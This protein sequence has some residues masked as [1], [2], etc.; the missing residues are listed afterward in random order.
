MASQ[1]DKLVQRETTVGHSQ[2]TAS[3]EYGPNSNGYRHQQIPGTGNR[4]ISVHYN[5]GP[6]LRQTHPS[7]SSPGSSTVE[8]HLFQDSLM[9]KCE[10]KV[11]WNRERISKKFFLKVN[12]MLPHFTISAEMI[13]NLWSLGAGIEP[14]SNIVGHI[15]GY[16]TDSFTQFDICECYWNRKRSRMSPLGD[17]MI[18]VVPQQITSV[19]RSAVSL[20]RLQLTEQEVREL[21]DSTNGQDIVL[22]QEKLNASLTPRDNFNRQD[23][24]VP[25]NFYNCHIVFSSDA[26]N[27]HL[28]LKAHLIFPNMTFEMGPVNPLKVVETPLTRSL[29]AKTAKGSKKETQSFRTGF[30]TLDQSKRVLPLECEDEMVSQFALVGIWVSGV[31]LSNSGTNKYSCLFNAKVWAACMR[32]ILWP[33]IKHRV[34]PSPN[35]NT[36]LLVCFRNEKTPLFVEVSTVVNND[37]NARWM[38]AQREFRIPRF[39]SKFNRLDL[40]FDFLNED[41]DEET[42]LKMSTIQELYH[43]AVRGGHGP[44]AFSDN[45]SAENV[46]NM[47]GSVDE[48]N[49]FNNDGSTLDDAS[50]DCPR[51]GQQR[52]MHFKRS[53]MNT[54]C[55]SMNEEDY[56]SNVPSRDNTAKKPTRRL[57]RN[58][59][60]Q[61]TP[62]VSRQ[63]GNDGNRITD[64]AGRKALD[65]E[66]HM[67]EIN[68][69]V[70]QR[71][72]DFQTRGNFGTRR[73]DF[74]NSSE[75]LMGLPLDGSTKQRKLPEPYPHPH[76]GN[77]N[78]VTSAHSSSMN[79]ERVLG[80][81]NRGQTPKSMYRGEQINQIRDGGGFIDAVS[82]RSESISIMEQFPNECSAGTLQRAES[83]VFSHGGDASANEVAS[84]FIPDDDGSQFYGGNA[85]EIILQ[86]SKQLKFLQQQLQELQAHVYSNQDRSEHGGFDQDDYYDSFYQEEFMSRE[87]EKPHG[88]DLMSHEK[89]FSIDSEAS[90]SPRGGTLD[91]KGRV[92]K[93]F[94]TSNHS[95]GYQRYHDGDQQ[96]HPQGQ[97]DGFAEKYRQFAAGQRQQN[98]VANLQEKEEINTEEDRQPEEVAVN[99]YHPEGEAVLHTE[100]PEMFQ[101]KDM[102]G[103]NT[104]QNSEYASSKVMRSR[105]FTS[106]DQN[107]PNLVVG[108]EFA[109]HTHG[110]SSNQ[111]AATLNR[112]HSGFREVIESEN[113]EE[114][115]WQRNRSAT[116][117][118]PFGH[119]K[120]TSDIDL[121]ELLNYEFASPC[122]R[123][124]DTS[125]QEGQR[126][127]HISRMGSVRGSQESLRL[128]SVDNLDKIPASKEFFTTEHSHKQLQ[129][130]QRT[131]SGI[132]AHDIN[133]IQEESSRITDIRVTPSNHSQITNNGQT[134]P[135]LFST[136]HIEDLSQQQVSVSIPNQDSGQYS[137]CETTHGTNLD[138]DDGVLKD[139]TNRFLQDGHICVDLRLN[140]RKGGGGEDVMTTDSVADNNGKA[141]SV[142]STFAS[143]DLGTTDKVAMRD[144]VSDGV[145]GAD[146]NCTA[147][148][149]TNNATGRMTALTKK[150]TDF[151]IDV[152]KI[153][154]QPDSDSSDD[155]EM[156]RIELKYLR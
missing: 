52:S 156:S 126:V 65:E 96:N 145:D 6:I 9:F 11:L 75:Y 89:P 151:T 32:Y 121:H 3:K 7:S 40:S 82:Q 45:F 8:E 22:A 133:I 98:R 136:N 123:G 73:G 105:S 19:G 114:R 24:V 39:N 125:A 17:V 124:S 21:F 109:E 116:Q 71:Y 97:F 135:N 130:H 155:E 127:R 35:K 129:N 142:S 104:I 119:Q 1:S 99:T 56:M 49:T 62:L 74:S 118:L 50:L 81:S 94:V 152:P 18:K 20:K 67:D 138:S 26:K 149:M 51:L 76:P 41:P 117:R 140:D 88:Y 43:E 55:S 153:L 37:F 13:Q 77:G 59:D 36:F 69:N 87:Q 47:L 68:D 95:S 38:V 85:E 147:T 101:Y 100:T 28:L 60:N 25:Q 139:C 120:N 86:Q 79:Q 33:D 42:P 132:D 107:D 64:W 34:S 23:E 108:H 29:V 57:S 111:M 31:N 144:Q 115:T 131:L 58:F 72:G 134:N 102:G 63:L 66:S 113:V 122:G 93:E 103:V 27:Q 53:T 46:S 70:P 54:D 15:V 143:G 112:V 10:K 154:Y 148:T 44:D 4:G 84:S 61:E 141:S 146:N 30:L 150:M 110:D 83:Y 137:V 92:P 91:G 12:K 90:F 2:A 14:K 78:F 106:F 5:N 80:E 48:N 128:D 16:R